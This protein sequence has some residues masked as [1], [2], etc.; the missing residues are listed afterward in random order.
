MPATQ[1]NAAAPSPVPIPIFMAREPNLPATLDEKQTLV[2]LAEIAEAKPPGQEP[3]CVLVRAIYP[4]HVSGSQEWTCDSTTYFK[5]DRTSPRTRSGLA[6]T[7]GADF[8]IERRRRIAAQLGI[9]KDPE[10]RGWRYIQV[11]SP[12]KPFDD[13]SPLGMTKETLPFAVP[14]DFTEREIVELVD[15]ARTCQTNES[16]MG[17][18]VHRR[19][20]PSLP[21]HRIERDGKLVRVMVGWQEG[22]LSGRGDFG[23]FK[24]NGSA[25]ELVDIGYWRY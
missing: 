17:I 5:P 15:A 21:I 13:Q 14:T 1:P 24:R 11:S 16:P 9:D 20:D 2:L 22:L 12:G 25:W 3:W 10:A 8:T 7:S 4:S 6:C 19:L 23:E 18:L